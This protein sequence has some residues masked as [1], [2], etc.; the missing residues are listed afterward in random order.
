MKTKIILSLIIVFTTFTAFC[1]KWTVNNISNTFSPPAIT[2]N[3]GDSVNFVLESMHN[4]V[5]VSLA[6]WT[7]NGNTAL[8]GGFQTSFGGGMVLPAQLTVGTHYYV[9]APHASVGMKAIIIVQSPTGITENSLKP[10]FSIYPNPTT[11]YIT[12][13]SNHDIYNLNFTILDLTGKKLISGKLN[14]GNTTINIS[15]FAEGIYFFQL[16]DDRKQTFK[17]IK[18]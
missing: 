5:E 8:S 4:A 12:V 15:Q 17:L 2:I 13:K 7:A 6:T 14:T 1:T 10:V 9:C 11:E 16:G 18:K 3:S